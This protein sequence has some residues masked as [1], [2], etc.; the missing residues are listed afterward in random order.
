MTRLFALLP[1]LLECFTMLFVD[2]LVTLRESPELFSLAPS[3]LIQ[4]R[5]SSVRRR[6]FSSTRPSLSAL[7]RVLCASSRSCSLPILSFVMTSTSQRNVVPTS[8]SFQIAATEANQAIVDLA[9]N[10]PKRRSTPH[11]QEKGI[12]LRTRSADNAFPIA[13]HS[14]S[15]SVRPNI[16]RIL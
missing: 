11:H 2:L 3:S 8:Q 5:S 16:A 15:P 9:E 4:P 1:H 7:S 10:R 12:S 6:S 13:C 14:V